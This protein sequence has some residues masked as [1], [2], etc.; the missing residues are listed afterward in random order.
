MPNGPSIHLWALT[1]S[2][3][4]AGGL[5]VD[6]EAAYG[7]G[8]V[9]DQQRVAAELPDPSEVVAMAGGVLHGTDGDD[10]GAGADQIPHATQVGVAGGH[11]H[12][13]DL[14]AAAP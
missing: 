12:F 8:A 4:M 9:D 13:A 3:S 11:R 10:A 7:L 6:Y 14:N 2:A 1:T 5:G